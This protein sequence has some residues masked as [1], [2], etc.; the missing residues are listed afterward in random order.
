MKKLDWYIVKKF[1]ATFFF[2]IMIL[3]VIAC[4]IDYSEKVEDFVAHKA[5]ALAIL[6]Y[7]KNFIP[8]ISALLFPLFI[9]IAT[10]FFTS[11]LAYKSEVIAILASGVSFQRFLRPYIIG[12]GMLCLL[13]L[14]SNHF[15][16]PQANKQRLAF[17]RTYISTASHASDRNVHLRL[18]K[19]L[20]V[21]VM[22]YDYQA[23]TGY[24][25]T[26]E[27]IDS[28]NLNYKIY[29][30]HIN[31][32]SIKKEYKLFEVR[33]R[34]FDG[35]KESIKLLADTIMKFPFKPRDLEE[36]EA[37]K[38][39]LTT[40]ELDTYIGREKLRG[41]ETLNFFYIEKHRR[42]AQPFAGFILT[43]I[44]VCIACKKVRG[45][46]GLH[47]A[48]GICISALYIMAM[49]FTTTFSTKA[50]LDPVLAVWI[51]NLLF[52]AVALYLYR[53]QVK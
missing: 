6:N 49:Q 35:A 8:H 36:D 24:H 45:G 48:I 32:D 53:R 25:F 4:V 11:K 13:S 38:D 14:V 18:S 28:T 5:P 20:Y 26:A 12:G 15:I 1:W 29:A 37:V 27:Y 22:T 2:A 52:G 3:A 41:R 42:T 43:I 16:V 47:L 31:Y 44:G 51:P 7:F 17:E 21:Y 34:R 19:D 9:F 33:I 10:I 46:S 50:G 40:P 23:N 30:G 39:A